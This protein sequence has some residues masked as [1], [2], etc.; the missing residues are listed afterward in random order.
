MNYNRS[1]SGINGDKSRHA[2][3]R[4]RGVQRR[5]K[6]RQL[7]AERKNQPKPADAPAAGKKPRT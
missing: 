1:M 4:K 6:I 3:N 2:I 7:L 5:A